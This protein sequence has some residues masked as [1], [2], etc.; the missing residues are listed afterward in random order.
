[1]NAL[2]DQLTGGPS[3]SGF[4][5]MFEEKMAA[6][7]VP[8]AFV[9][10]NIKRFYIINAVYGRELGDQVLKTVYRLF[11]RCLHSGE[12]VS[13]VHTNTYFLVLEAHSHQ[14]LQKRMLELDDAVYF[15]SE[16]EP[17]QKVFLSMGGYLVTQQDVSYLQAMDCANYCRTNSPDRFDHNTHY[18]IYNATIRDNRE[19][20]L[21][22]LRM[23][24]PAMQAGNFVVYF[25]PKYEL[26]SETVV[27]AEALIRWQDPEEGMI[28]LYEFIP[29]FEESGF[30][31]Q[32]DY[33]VFEQVLKW[34]EHRLDRGLPVVPVSV[35]LS[36]SHFS[37]T[38][39]F[40][41]KFI[42]IF[43]RYH[44]PARYLEFEIS[45]SIMLDEYGRLKH[46]TEKIREYGF[47]CS[48][49]DVGSGYSSLN[50][51]KTL[52]VDVLKLDRKMFSEESK[53]RGKV[54]VAGI[55]YIAHGLGMSVVAEGVETREYVDFL[56]E[57]QCEMVQGYYYAKP[58]PVPEFEHYL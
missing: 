47:C 29:P 7:Q 20:S 37:S 43:Q 10:I 41:S 36:K 17:F 4:Q 5:R 54:V 46:L 23:A 53:E 11:E 40:E 24:N 48:L 26:K 14:E 15:S 39:F 38:G 56:K 52:P 44:V 2:I 19:R 3:E 30:I 33:F 35:N 34:L 51:I 58:M 55:L 27:G 16:L 13:R 42:P 28:P 8:C 6:G 31:R 45:E 25:Q 9:S 50:T 21:K 1:M 57:H 12:F 18:E 22:L 32:I 49:D